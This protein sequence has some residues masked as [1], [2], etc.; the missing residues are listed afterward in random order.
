ML[1]NWDKLAQSFEWIWKRNFFFFRRKMH[2]TNKSLP[3]CFLLYPSRSFLSPNFLLITSQMLIGTQNYIHKVNKRYTKER[4]IKDKSAIMLKKNQYQCCFQ[5]FSYM[6]LHQ[7]KKE[8]ER[9]FFSLSQ[10]TNLSFR[11][12]IFLVFIWRL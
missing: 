2:Q 1:A 5:L 12:I 3:L 6:V 8:L 9:I 11:C 4:E 7:L 10:I